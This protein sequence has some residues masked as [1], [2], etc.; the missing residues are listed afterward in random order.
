LASFYISFLTLSVSLVPCTW[1]FFAFV[2]FSSTCSCP[3]YVSLFLSCYEITC[4][5]LHL[6]C[7]PLFYI[8]FT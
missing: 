3:L 8:L 6:S 5:S 4:A 2:M 1:F 7:G